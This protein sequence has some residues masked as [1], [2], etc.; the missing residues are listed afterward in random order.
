MMSTGYIACGV[1][2]CNKISI[3]QGKPKIPVI[4]QT[5]SFRLRHRYVYIV[6]RIGIS[7]LV[8]HPTS[9]SVSSPNKNNIY[10]F[11]EGAAAP[12][13]PPLSWP[14]ASEIKGTHSIRD[15]KNS[16]LSMYNLVISCC[17]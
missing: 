9:A 13:D 17:I 12:P 2:F 10:F 5:P 7:Q 1:H 6:W 11:P 3:S 4:L 16:L 14:E 8:T 15:N